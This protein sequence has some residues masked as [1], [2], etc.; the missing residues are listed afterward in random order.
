M[1]NGRHA[2]GLLRTRHEQVYDRDNY[3]D[4]NIRRFM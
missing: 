1:A 3:K 4:A 2:N